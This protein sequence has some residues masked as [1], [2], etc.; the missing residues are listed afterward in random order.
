[1]VEDDRIGV[2]VRGRSGRTED[3]GNMTELAE[4][5][6]LRSTRTLNIIPYPL[7]ILIVHLTLFTKPYKLSI[8]PP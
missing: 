8:N 2:W 3:R 5:L 1:M 6:V 7:L 4:G